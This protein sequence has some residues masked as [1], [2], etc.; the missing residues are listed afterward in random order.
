[1]HLTGRL[2]DPITFD[3]QWANQCMLSGNSK[4]SNQRQPLTTIINGIDWRWGGCGWKATR[5]LA[6]INIWFWLSDDDIDWRWR[7]WGRIQW[8]RWWKRSISSLPSTCSPN[9]PKNLLMPDTQCCFV[10]P[11]NWINLILLDYN[12][13]NAQLTYEVYT[14]P[15]LIGFPNWQCDTIEVGWGIWMYEHPSVDDEVMAPPEAFAP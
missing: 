1:M 12:Q 9:L 3:T 6:G 2:F 11:K 15:Y 4:V 14:S 5:C 7:W 10:Q 8:W 13:P